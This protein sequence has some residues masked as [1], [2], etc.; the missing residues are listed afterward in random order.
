M[1]DGS[2]LID[3]EGLLERMGPGVADL[4]GKL[5]PNQPLK[6][7]TWFRVGGPAELYF[8][9]A[10]VEDLQLFLQLLPADAPVHVM[11]LASNSL[12]RDGGLLGAVVRL[13]AKAF[14]QAKA[15]PETLRIEAGAGMADR[16]LAAVARDADIGGFHFYHGIPGSLGGALRMNAGANGVET[17]SRFVSLDAVNRQGERVTLDHA[18]MGFTYRH[19]AASDDLIFV[20]AT[21]E[22]EP[23][24]P[25]DIQAAMDAVQK[26]REENQPIKE[27]TSG[28]TFKNPDGGS[29]WKCVDA[30]G[31][32]GFQV[33]GA[34]MSP[35][36]CNFMI[37]T[38]DATAYDLEL[39]GE[40]VRKRVFEH[41]GTLLQWEVKR[42]G[43]FTPG[44]SV[45]T[46]HP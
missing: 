13:T 46:F 1:S 14:N 27:R 7:F 30:A 40:T 43:V 36:H 3:G 25:E 18:A 26:H 22:G 17:V 33:G 23:S 28:S 42:L 24:T 6:D 45:E 15:D 19:T 16:R 32:R 5:R 8:V 10:D 35:M 20:S 39:L 4:R 41:S 44:R 21:F 9:P 29:A 37:N 38:G 12:I 34:Q 11:G 31:L 2:P